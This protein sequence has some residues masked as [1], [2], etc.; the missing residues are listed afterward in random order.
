MHGGG[1]DG[2]GDRTYRKVLGIGLERDKE[3]IVIHKEIKHRGSGLESK[4]GGVYETV[5]DIIPSRYE[6]VGGGVGSEV[7]GDGTYSTVDD[8]A[9]QLQGGYSKIDY[10]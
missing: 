8:C 2:N 4:G 1:G 3:G 5:T 7:K 6:T 10:E 9:D